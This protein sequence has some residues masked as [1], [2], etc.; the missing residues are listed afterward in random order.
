MA[1]AG[2]RLILNVGGAEVSAWRQPEPPSMIVLP[3]GDQVHCPALDTT[4]GGCQLVEWDE[5]PSADMV[6][7][8]RDRRLALPVTV[9]LAGARTFALDVDDVSLVN[10]Q[11][12]VSGAILK[13]ISS[14]SSTAPFRDHN[15]NTQNLNAD[16]WISIGQQIDAGRT[17]I[18]AASWTIK[19][20]SPIPDDYTSDS[21][22][23]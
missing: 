3:N 8:E 13:K 18:Y 1:K 17:A 16:D 22:W 21:H 9:T 12:R 20:L 2:Y 4:Y 19:A 15:N 7:I 5:A 11:G 14:D 10:I 23:P 6:D